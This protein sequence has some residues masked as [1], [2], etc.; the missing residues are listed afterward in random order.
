MCKGYLTFLDSAVNAVCG[1]DDERLMSSMHDLKF[2]MAV[3][4]FELC[5]VDR[6]VG[7][8]SRPT[9]QKLSGSKSNT[10]VKSS[11]SKNNTSV[12]SSGSN[13]L[14]RED[15]VSNTNNEPDL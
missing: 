4:S 12:K 6:Q 1:I 11:G 5:S 7:A 2:S 9:P 8:I 13:N 15:T 3:G 10:S 14:M